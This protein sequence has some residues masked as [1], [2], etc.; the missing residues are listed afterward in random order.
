MGDIP[1]AAARVVD[2]AWVRRAPDHGRPRPADLRRSALLVD[3][4]NSLFRADQP[5]HPQGAG[6]CPLAGRAL[7]EL[8][9][10]RDPRT[11]RRGSARPDPLLGPVDRADGP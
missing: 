8:V 7:P 5:T 9:A 10:T 4:R 6:S 2:P 11:G 3:G 1:S